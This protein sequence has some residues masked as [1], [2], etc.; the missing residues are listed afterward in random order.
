MIPLNIKNNEDD[1]EKLFKKFL[2]R[3]NSRKIV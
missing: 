1:K 2:T 3:E